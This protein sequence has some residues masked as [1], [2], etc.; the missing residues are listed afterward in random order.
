MY[1]SMYID[2]IAQLC[3]IMQQLLVTGLSGAELQ[4]QI[5]VLKLGAKQNALWI[6]LTNERSITRRYLTPPCAALSATSVS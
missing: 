2:V 4:L 5:Q 1:V 3:P 6:S